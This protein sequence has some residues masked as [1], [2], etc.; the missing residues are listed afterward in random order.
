MKLHDILRLSPLTLAFIACG[1]SAATR[2]DMNL[3]RSPLALRQAQSLRA[4]SDEALLALPGEESLKVAKS[5]KERNGKTYQRIDQHFRGVPVWGDQL[6]MVKDSRGRTIEMHGNLLRDLARDIGDVSPSFDARAALAQAK[7]LLA[8]N[9]AVTGGLQYSNESALLRI[10]FDEAT[11]KARLAYVVDFYAEDL[12]NNFASRP[13]TLIDAHTGEIIKRW[14]NLN[15]AQNAGGPG[16]NA[17]IGQYQYGVGTAK[18]PLVVTDACEMNSTNVRAVDMNGAGSSSSYNTPFKFTCP[19]NNYKTVNGAYSPLNDAFYFGGV[20][21]NMYNDWF[22]A[23]PITQQLSMRVHA[24]TNWENATWNGQ[25]MTFGDGATTFY[26]LVSLDVSAHEV[27]HGFTQQNS[28]L[29]YS[30]QSGGMNEAFSDI[31][32]E[33][34]EYYARGSND[35]LIGADITKTLTAL[36]YM[37]D[38]TRDGNSIGHASNY[39]SGMDVHHSSGVYNRAFYLLAHKAGWNSKKA[40]EVFVRANKNYWTASSTYNQGACGMESAATDLAY[41]VADVTDAFNTVGVSCNTTP[42]PVVVLSNGVPVTGISGS[43]GQ[44]R[45]YSLAVPSGASGLNFKTTGGTGDA[46]L[47]VKFGSAPTT[48]SYDC[49]SESSSSTE[50]CNIATAQVGTYYVLLYGYS[51]YSGVSLTGSYTTGGGGGGDS[52]ENTTDVAIPDNNATGVTSSIDIAS[53][54]TA[55]SVSVDVNIVHTYIGD[56][57]VDLLAP[58]GTVFNLHNRSGGS[59]DNL[60]K[61]YS[62]NTG[63]V[64]RTGAWKLRVK[65]RAAI[66]TGYINSWKLTINN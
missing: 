26:P 34:A 49:K 65:D 7:G 57:V 10:V 33:A 50:T 42:V 63:G 66:D 36:R 16:G 51:A 21:F 44:E 53:S 47:Y 31:A 28:N 54:G 6:V 46:D 45:K 64:A 30:G 5:L 43:T 9:R 61:T 29:T 41:A 22:G 60:V 17:K 35:F 3:E 40:F 58:N 24:G 4:Q 62:V 55:S 37:D 12:K 8:Q 32:G 59:A 23:R 1:A 20:V 27:S 11:K 38:P 18:G 14:E 56:L 52:G 39:T 13:M 25:A 19:T 48:S 15:T 2:V